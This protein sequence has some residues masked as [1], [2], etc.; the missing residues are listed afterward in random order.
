M[1]SMGECRHVFGHKLTDGILLHK[2]ITGPDWDDVR[3]LRK[4]SLKKPMLIQSL[5]TTITSQDAIYFVVNIWTGTVQ[6]LYKGT[7]FQTHSK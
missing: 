6:M 3:C 5:K 2:K 1:S 4:R 7:K